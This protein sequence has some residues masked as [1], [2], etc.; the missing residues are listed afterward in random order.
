MLA[1]VRQRLLDDAICGEVKS[2]RQRNCI[3]LGAHVDRYAGGAGVGDEPA[4]MLESGL[5]CERSGAVGAQD[6]EQPSHL[7]H[8]LAGGVL[9]VLE[10][11]DL[12]GL[13]SVQAAAHGLRLDGDD[14]DAVRDDV[15]QLARDAP[16]F[17][18]D[19]ALLALGLTLPKVL[20][21]LIE[22]ADAGGALAQRVAHAPRPAVQ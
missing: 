22:L 2:W 17:V 4:D 9:D 8:R 1:T 3:A 19:R 6:S 15:V 13:I 12:R 14:A 21:F 7:R 20:S 5:R 10:V 18:G 16:A 11:V